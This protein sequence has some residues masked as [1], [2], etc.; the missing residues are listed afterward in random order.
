MS[1]PDA[2][3]FLASLGAG[4]NIASWNIRYGNV[5]ANDYSWLASRVPEQ[6]EVLERKF[7]HPQ[8]RLCVECASRNCVRPL[9]I[10]QVWGL[11]SV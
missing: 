8:K 10:G 9:H 4:V 11:T 1:A 7:P 2:R 6:A 5:H 3:A